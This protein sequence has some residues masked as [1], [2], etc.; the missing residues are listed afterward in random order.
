MRTPTEQVRVYLA[1]D[2]AIILRLLAE[3][4]RDDDAINI[5]GHSSNAMSAITD[6]AALDPDVIVIDLALEHSNGFDVMKSIA[7]RDDEAR[8]VVIVLSNYAAAPYREA[9]R[10]LGADYFF[11][12]N[13]G[14]TELIKTIKSMVASRSASARTDRAPESRRSSG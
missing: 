8:P 2:S 13:G 5:V 11:D 9:A 1:E 14:I 4:F 12:K 7:K 3:L 10:R 6:V